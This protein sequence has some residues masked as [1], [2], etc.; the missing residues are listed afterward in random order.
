M[1]SDVGS[2]GLGAV[3]RP[4][5]QALGWR[6]LPARVTLGRVLLYAVSPPSL[7]DRPCPRADHLLLWVAEWPLRGPGP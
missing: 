5:S 1:A 2:I 6:A 7:S 3:F 4:G